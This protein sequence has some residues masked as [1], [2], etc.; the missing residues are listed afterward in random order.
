MTEQPRFSPGQAAVVNLGQQDVSCRIFGY[1]PGENAR[2]FHDVAWVYHVVPEGADF[3]LNVA[4]S[5]VRP[6]AR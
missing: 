1:E 5:A 2:G 4:E 3:G 6:A